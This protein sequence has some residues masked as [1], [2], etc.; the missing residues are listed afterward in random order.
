MEVITILA[1]GFVCMACFL[2]GAKVGQAVA[3]GEEVKL[4]ANP[5]TAVKER[6]TKQEAEYEQN[7]LNTI[8][9]NIDRYD[10]TNAGQK[11]VPRG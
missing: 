8:L 2:M 6:Q 3:K 4:P 11:E 1:I 9:Q 5:L 10:G 7:R